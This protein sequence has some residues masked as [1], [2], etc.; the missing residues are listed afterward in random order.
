MAYKIPPVDHYEVSLIA[1]IGQAVRHGSLRTP[2]Y[3]TATHLCG[4]VNRYLPDRPRGSP[5]CKPSDL[6]PLLER[7]GLLLVETGNI[8]AAAVLTVFTTRFDSCALQRVERSDAK[9]P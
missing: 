1:A 6:I 9:W 7:F 5:A 3:F 8:P 2:T 4:L